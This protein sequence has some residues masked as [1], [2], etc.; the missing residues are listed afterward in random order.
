MAP[1]PALCLTGAQSTG[2]S[3]LARRIGERFGVP[4][5]PEFARQYALEAGRGLTAEDVE[6][7]A[8]GEIR[9]LDAALAAG[10]TLVILDTDL[11]ST[12]VYAEYYYGSVPRWI[13]DEACR[14]LADLYLVLEPDVP[15]TG[16]AARDPES[17]RLGHHAALLRLLEE[18]DATAV[19]VGGSWEERERQVVEWVTKLVAERR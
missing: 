11:I 17:D 10:S 14:R 13:R 15:F 2:K 18:L 5:A 4:V 6:P 16:D 1:I 7:I 8:R 12:V 3:E 9:N 19:T